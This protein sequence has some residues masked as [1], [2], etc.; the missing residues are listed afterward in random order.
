MTMRGVGVG[1]YLDMLKNEHKKPCTTCIEAGAESDC[2][3]REL[4]DGL[5]EWARRMRTELGGAQ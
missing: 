1:W 4:L 2:V 3:T 5:E